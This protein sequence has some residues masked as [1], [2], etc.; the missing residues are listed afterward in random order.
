MSLEIHAL[1]DIKVLKL[2]YIKPTRAFLKNYSFEL[3]LVTKAVFIRAS[4]KLYTDLTPSHFSACTKAG[5]VVAVI[6]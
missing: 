5:A 6:V 2:E 3:K 1:I 4:L